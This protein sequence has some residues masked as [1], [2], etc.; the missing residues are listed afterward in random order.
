MFWIE[1]TS[2]D[3]RDTLVYGEGLGYTSG[4]RP[5][6]GTYPL[7]RAAIT[8]VRYV[9]YTLFKVIYVICVVH[10]NKTP[11]IYRLHYRVRRRCHRPLQRIGR[12]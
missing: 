10:K 3:G 6:C 12:A 9:A 2:R 8:R 11:F 4:K 1:E 7:M 5:P